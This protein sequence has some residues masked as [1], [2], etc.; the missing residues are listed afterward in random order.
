LS[1][2]YSAALHPA[3]QDDSPPLHE[4]AASLEDPVASFCLES[5][6]QDFFPP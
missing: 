5:R 4:G 3:Q 6:A 1:L 2:F